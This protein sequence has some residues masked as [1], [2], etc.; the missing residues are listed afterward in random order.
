ML[1]EIVNLSERHT[2]P[3]SGSQQ[4]RK[5]GK[6]QDLAKASPSSTDYDWRTCYARRSIDVHVVL[7]FLSLGIWEIKHCT[8]GILQRHDILSLSRLISHTNKR[9][10]L[11]IN[12]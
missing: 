10:N 8:S 6:L 11:I 1:G 4:A 7:R 5:T 9:L 12:S 3:E 2:K